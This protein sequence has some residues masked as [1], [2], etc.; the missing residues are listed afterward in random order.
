MKSFL[1]KIIPSFILDLYRKEKS[2]ERMKEIE[3]AKEEGNVHTRNSILEFL[4][5]S[6]IK[7][8]DA[9]ML[10]SSLTSLGFV[11]GGADAVI[12]AFLT[13]VG[14]SGTLMMPSFPASGFN[15]DHLNAGN[16]FDVRYTAGKTGIISETFRKMQGVRRSLHPTDPVIAF[17]PKA[18]F[19]TNEHFG[20]LT[21]YNE[22]SPFMKLCELNGKII[23]V[24]VDLNSLTNLH[25]LE[26][27]VKDFKFPIYHPKV[28]DCALIDEN[29]G[30]KIMKT[31]VHDPAWSRKRKCNELIPVFTKDGCL[32][33]L[34]MG[35]TGVYLIDAKGM[36]ESMLKNYREKGI[37]MYTPQ[38]S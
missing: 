10:H 32:K 9:V 21:P 25:T 13:S 20:Q 11:E 38:G 2:K 3:K 5:I 37:T 8:G 36:H 28:F 30:K 23:L 35:K 29:G 7:E 17:G 31:K 15:F 1:K 34:K 16:V 33:E 12:N 4:R 18:E 22:K 24:G 26:D 27:A 6:G 14:N 19:L